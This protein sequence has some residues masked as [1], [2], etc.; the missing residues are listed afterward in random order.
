MSGLTADDVV[1]VANLAK[2]KLT[3]EQIEK[4][5]GQLSKVITHVAELKEVNTKGIEPTSQT[6]GLTN[7]IRTDQVDATQTLSVE[8]ALSGTEKT[9]NGYFVVPAIL[10]KDS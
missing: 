3:T 5:K 6:T 4:F 9:S 10:Q 1:H 7:V 8:A 2:L